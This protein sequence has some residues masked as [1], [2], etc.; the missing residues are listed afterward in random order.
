MSLRNKIK[1]HKQSNGHMKAENVK[2]CADKQTLESSIDRGNE[3]RFFSTNN[4]FRVVYKIGKLGRP[5][6]DLPVEC[7]I[8]KLNGVDIG[9]TLQSDK[10]CQALLEHIGQEMRVKV[11]KL[12]ISND[13][14]K[15]S[16][17]VDESTSISKKSALIVYIKACLPE[18]S[19]VETQPCTFY[20]DLVELDG[21]GAECIFTS[22]MKCLN[23]HGF[24]IQV[25]SEKLICFACD[26]ASVMLGS[27]TGVGTRIQQAFPNVIVW[28]CMDHRLEL[29]V[30]EVCG[31]NHFKIFFDKLYCLYHTS[32][33]NRR[34]LEEC[35]RELAYS[36]K[37]HWTDT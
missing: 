20:L 12:I 33:K 17:M 27:K 5:F 16:V 35:C 19:F 1:R 2:E 28:H 6:T 10:S 8:Q 26:G 32:A 37:H 9:S 34:E 30:D 3:K 22:L 15:I 25:L 31:I 14:V 29:A 7:D 36:F 23:G 11:C 13:D 24:T 21:Q 4:L 18:E